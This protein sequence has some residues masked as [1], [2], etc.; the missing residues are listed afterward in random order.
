MWPGHEQ[1]TV[2]D[3]DKLSRGV[4]DGYADWDHKIVELPRDVAFQLVAQGIDVILDD[5][6]WARDEGA[7]MRNAARR[8]AGTRR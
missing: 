3:L 8:P 2:A 5:G 1:L 6:F 4:I 7:V